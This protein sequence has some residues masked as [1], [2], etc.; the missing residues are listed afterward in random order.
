[1]S[2][3]VRITVLATGFDVSRSDRPAT[4]Q[5]AQAEPT[6][7]GRT[8]GQKLIEEPVPAMLGESELDIPAFLRRR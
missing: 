8:E 5:D 4:K 1:M 3:E 7:E 2:G 6:R